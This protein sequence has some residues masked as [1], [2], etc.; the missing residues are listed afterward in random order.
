VGKLILVVV[1]VAVV[2]YLAV[3]LIETRGRLFR[4]GDGGSAA[5]RRPHPPRRPSGPM[6]PDDDPEFLR[7]LNRRTRK[8]DPGTED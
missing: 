4:R 8:K 7:D 1:I 5:V 3:R 6:G 2:V